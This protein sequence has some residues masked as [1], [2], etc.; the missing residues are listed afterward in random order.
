MGK[1]VLILL[2][3]KHYIFFPWEY[4][5]SLKSKYKAVGDHKAF[6]SKSGASPTKRYSTV[7]SLIPICKIKK[8]CYLEGTPLWLDL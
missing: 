6:I 3:F 8:D 2:I 7:C 4:V 1:Y 5:N